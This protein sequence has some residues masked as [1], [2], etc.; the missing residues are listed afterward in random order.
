MAFFQG[1]EEFDDPCEIS[2]Y[3][4]FVRG[5]EVEVQVQD[6]G[7]GAGDARYLAL[8]RYADPPFGRE[9]AMNLYGLSL[10]KTAPTVDGAL[11]SIHWD[12]FPPLD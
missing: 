7:E 2:L 5:V 10:G 11:A 9:V 12:V 3:R 1:R 8:A 4:V 6:F